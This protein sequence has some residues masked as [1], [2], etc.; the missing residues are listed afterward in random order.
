MVIGRPSI[1]ELETR[2]LTRLSAFFPLLPARLH[3]LSLQVAVSPANRGRPVPKHAAILGVDCSTYP[4][5][6]RGTSL[7]TTQW[8]SK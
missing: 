1:Y 8:D 3:G 5:L 7:A 6:V 4:N 2:I